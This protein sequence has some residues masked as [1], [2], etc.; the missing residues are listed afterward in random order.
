[1]NLPSSTGASGRARWPRRW[2]A[3]LALVLFAIAVAWLAWRPGTEP[4]A[5][6]VPPQTE[7]A[8]AAHVPPAAAAVLPAPA[9]VVP[10]DGAAPA[11][12]AGPAPQP[13]VAPASGKTFAV[14][15][16]GRLV[17]N[18]QTR[19]SV[20]ALVALT[21]PEQLRAAAQAQVQDLPAAAAAEAL[22]LVERYNAYQAAQK[23][24]FP[25]GDAPLVPQEALAELDGLHALRV[26]YFGQEGAQS[27]FGQEEATARQL[28]EWM[29]D[30]T[31]P[32]LTMEQRAMRAQARYDAL[33]GASPGR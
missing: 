23:L 17:R 21:P 5:P 22:D 33:R 28:L 13:D 8:L 24:S 20:E 29:R 18:E 31:T 1:M 4:G 26:S 10:P 6:A 19:L 9:V 12:V 11:V 7:A 16:S 32:G 14:D 25:P 30:D 2:A 15:A 27:L 3:A